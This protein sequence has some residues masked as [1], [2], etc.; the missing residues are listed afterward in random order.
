MN[1]YSDAYA[2][3]HPESEVEVKAVSDYIRSIADELT[4]YLTIHSKGQ[5]ILVP[6]GYE[7]APYPPTYQDLMQIGR[8]GAVDMYKLY[9][10]PYR[11][12][13]SSD[14]LCNSGTSNSYLSSH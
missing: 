14:V 8:R 9:Q 6:F 11:V 5:Y 3:Q 10:K 2:G 4:L 1:P 12:G 7:N 13:T